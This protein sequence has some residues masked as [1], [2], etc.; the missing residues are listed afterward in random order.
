M[1]IERTMEITKKGRIFCGT[2][3]FQDIEVRGES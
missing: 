3:H 1:N 2:A